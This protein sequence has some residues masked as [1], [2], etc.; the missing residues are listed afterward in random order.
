M[1]ILEDGN[2]K[3]Q[4]SVYVLLS[5]EQV[6]PIRRCARLLHQTIVSVKAW[7]TAQ[8]V[9]ESRS[10]KIAQSYEMHFLVGSIVKNDTISI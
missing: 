4:K 2:E 6:A 3:T 5:C 10:S 9:M 7:K 8:S 1:L